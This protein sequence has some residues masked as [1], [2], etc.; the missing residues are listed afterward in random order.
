[1]FHRFFQ[2]LHNSTK[3]MR[4]STFISL[5]LLSFIQAQAQNT[6]TLTGSV[7]D[8]LTQEAL[9]GVSVKLENTELGAATDAEG[10][11]RIAGIPPRSYNVSF[12]YLGYSTQI[13]YNVVITTGN[14]G[15]LNY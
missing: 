5:F 11:F 13:K 3:I 7:R 9:I 15:Q 12:S 1:M 14:S 4:L 2:H 10:N 8:K 6:G